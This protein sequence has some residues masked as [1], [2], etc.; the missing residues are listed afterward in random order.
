MKCRCYFVD[1]TVADS[2]RNELLISHKTIIQYLSLFH[3]WKNKTTPTSSQIIPQS[4]CL[5]FLPVN[6][7]S[8]LVLYHVWDLKLPLNLFN[9][10][11][12][13]R[14]SYKYDI[15]NLKQYRLMI[16]KI[17]VMALNNS[18]CYQLLNILFLNQGLHSELHPK[19]PFF[20]FWD[21]ILSH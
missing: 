7:D 16:S 15:K 3:R 17:Y 19:P 1:G 10:H 20:Y 2:E 11:G 6:Y 18:K 14:G 5:N 12:F 13:S 8:V 21:K 4:T 9:M